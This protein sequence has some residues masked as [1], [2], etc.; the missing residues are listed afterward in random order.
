MLTIVIATSILCSSIGK[1]KKIKILAISLTVLWGKA[2]IQPSLKRR[3]LGTKPWGF[4][5]YFSFFPSALKYIR[6][7]LRSRKENVVS[8]VKVCK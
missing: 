7:K 6:A 4:E 3:K 2:K 1:H 8:V 5:T